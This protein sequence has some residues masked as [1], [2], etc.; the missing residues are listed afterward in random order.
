MPRGDEA[1]PDGGQ[2]YL[3]RIVTLA[4]IGLGGITVLLVV[5]GLAWKHLG[6]SVPA[7]PSLN[8]SRQLR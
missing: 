1:D 6:S 4:T 8:G 5:A 2:A 3:N 7:V